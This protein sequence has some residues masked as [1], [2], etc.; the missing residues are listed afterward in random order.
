MFG[1][2]EHFICGELLWSISHFVLLY[3]LL[4]KTE[5]TCLFLHI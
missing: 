3:I 1:I 2:I 5:K 4:A